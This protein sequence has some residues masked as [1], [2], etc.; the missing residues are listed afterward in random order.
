MKVLSVSVD[1]IPNDCYHCSLCEM[2]KS[3]GLS[4][5]YYKCALEPEINC[6]SVMSYSEAIHSRPDY[7]PLKVVEK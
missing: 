4:D 3:R 5:T 1:E 7:C 6:Y 2:V